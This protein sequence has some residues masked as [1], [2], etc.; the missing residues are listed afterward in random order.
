[1]TSGQRNPPRTTRQDS[2]TAPRLEMKPEGAA[3]GHVDG[4]WWPRSKDPGEEFPALLAALGTWVGPV[5]RVSYHL[6][7]W[8]GIERKVTIDGRAVRFEGF[9]SM[10]HDTVV[11]IGAD[12]RRVSLLVVPPDTPGGMARAVLRA[13]SALDSTASAADILASNGSRP[14]ASTQDGQRDLDR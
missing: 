1:M 3:G 13:S 9:H 2:R 4:G 14:R 7:T 5:S 6:G 11:V 8:S 12:A 10:D